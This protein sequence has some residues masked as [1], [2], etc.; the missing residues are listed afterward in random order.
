MRCFFRLPLMQRN[1]TRMGKVTKSCATPRWG[2]YFRQDLI[3]NC[4][5][6]RR[7]F[8]I[9]H[10]TMVTVSGFFTVVD[11]NLEAFVLPDITFSTCTYVCV[12]AHMYGCVC[13]KLSVVTV[14]MFDKRL[15]SLIWKQFLYNFAELSNQ[16]NSAHISDLVI[17]FHIIYFMYTKG[18][19]IPNKYWYGMR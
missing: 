1:Y 4:F 12:H 10:K 13:T 3:R 15:F 16:E 8:L 11:S 5:V 17:S 9:W 7:Y 19:I 18:V 14:S 6:V 2:L